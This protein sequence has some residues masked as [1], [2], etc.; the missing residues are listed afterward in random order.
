[1]PYATGS[2]V[3]IHYEVEGSGAP[4]VLHP[5]FMGSVDDWYSAGSVDALKGEN[6]LVLI[7]PRGRE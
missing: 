1:M 3:R 2:G 7:D 6:T 4:L 5:G